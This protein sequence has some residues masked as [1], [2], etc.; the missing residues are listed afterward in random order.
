[1]ASQTRTPDDARQGNDGRGVIRCC[2]VVLEL[3][4]DR[5]STVRE[6]RLPG[7]M[8][9][10]AGSVGRVLES[11]HP[12]VRAWFEG[13]FPAG[14]TEPQAAG[15]Q[16]IA[17]GRHT[18]IAAPTGSGKT[19]AAFLVCIDQFYRAHDCSCDHDLFCGHEAGPPPDGPARPA[20]ARAGP[21]VVYVSPLKALATDIHQNLEA[22]LREIAGMAGQR[23]RA[24][25]AGDPGRGQDR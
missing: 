1:M 8:S 24:R 21:Q 18:L 4:R 16:E 2:P 23:A 9:V 7:G 5:M 17:A 12:A 22:P 10:F 6:V 14:P 11:F 3:R 15:W 13:R 19:L 25:R 20:Q